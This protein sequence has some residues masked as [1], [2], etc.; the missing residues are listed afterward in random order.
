MAVGRPVTTALYSLLQEIQQG[1]HSNDIDY[2]YE[3]CLLDL[4]TSNKSYKDVIN[5][6]QFISALSI[7]RMHYYKIKTLM[8]NST[9]A[10]LEKS[11]SRLKVNSTAK[12]GKRHYLAQ[13]ID[14]NGRPPFIK[15]VSPE[16][17][18]LFIDL[19]PVNT[20]NSSLS[21]FSSFCDVSKY[22]TYWIYIALLKVTSENRYIDLGMVNKKQPLTYDIKS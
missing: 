21:M 8:L 17:N 16:T 9:K 19:S 14:A 10:A 12:Y 22:V 2:V 5:K 11:K 15:E 4:E 20:I 6:F 13:T 7:D 1:Q 3:P 18:V